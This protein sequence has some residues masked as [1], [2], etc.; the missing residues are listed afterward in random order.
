[1]TRK[2]IMFLRMR[3]LLVAAILISAASASAGQLPNAGSAGQRAGAR[4]GRG[5]ADLWPD[6]KK[7]LLVADVQ[8]GYHHDAI[9]HGMAI[10]ERLGRESGAYVAFLRTDAQLI[11]KQPILGQG[12]YAGGNNQIRTLDFFHAG[13]FFPPRDGAM[14]EQQKKKL[15]SLVRDHGQ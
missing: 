9:N 12:K 4:G 10:V 8:T 3:L 15:L 14:S 1:M 2:D 7:V 6:K 5:Q 13:F 11:T